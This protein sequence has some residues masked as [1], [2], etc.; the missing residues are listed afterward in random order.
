M[1]AIPD[2][3]RCSW[4]VTISAVWRRLEARGLACAL[5]YRGLAAAATP[6]RSRAPP[7]AARRAARRDAPAR[8]AQ[9]KDGL[10]M[11]KSLG[12]VLEPGPLVAAYGSDAVRLF[13][14]K[15]VLLGQARGRAPSLQQW[16]VCAAA[17][18][19][20]GSLQSGR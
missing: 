4:D 5:T 12:N 6:G 11:G 18:A 1:C 20:R 10:K 9:T 13:F 17:S 19:T 16:V 8:V 7:R 14:T 3:K 2:T 15:E